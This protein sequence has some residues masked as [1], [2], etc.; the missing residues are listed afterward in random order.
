MKKEAPATLYSNIVIFTGGNHPPIDALWRAV[1][2]SSVDFIIACD[3]GLEY[4]LA[5]GVTPNLVIGDFDSL[6]DK[7]LLDFFPSECVLRYPHDKDFTDTQ[8]AL[9]YAAKYKAP[10]GKVGIF[11]GD[12]G[13]LDH[14][15]SLYNTFTTDYRADYW[16]TSEQTLYLLRKKEVWEIFDPNSLPLGV[17]RLWNHWKGGAIET[18]GLQ[19]EG[20]IFFKTGIATSCNRI[21]DCNKTGRAV[22]RVKRG[23]FLLCVANVVSVRKTFA[24][25]R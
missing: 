24:C 18:E 6:S 9:K 16:V 12:G 10:F 1:D 23:E 5:D 11:G 20:K 2:K 17:I 21:A 15:F 14:F 19:W 3:K 22:I 4:A 25:V 8:L 7:S 13:R